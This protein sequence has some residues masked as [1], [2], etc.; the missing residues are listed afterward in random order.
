MADS[1]LM[2]ALIGLGGTILGSAIV[3]TSQWLLEGRKQETEK[4]KKK[5]EKLEELVSAIH[6]HKYWALSVLDTLP[7]LPSEEVIAKLPPSPIGKVEAIANVYFPEFRKLVFTLNFTSYEYQQ[8]KIDFLIEKS[9]DDRQI[10]RA[11]YYGHFNVLLD[12]IRDYAKRE[13]Q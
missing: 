1:S 9:E 2:P 13:F 4:R 10:L 12:E 5:A 6:E 3:L 7:L 11:T 8:S